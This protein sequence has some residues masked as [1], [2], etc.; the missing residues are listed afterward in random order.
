MQPE[1]WEKMT[2]YTPL[3]EMVNL[4]NIKNVEKIEENIWVIKN[5]VS[6][7]ILKEYNDY[8]QTVPEE[9]WWKRNKDWW[10]GKYLLVDND[11]P[12]C[13]VSRKLTEQI[14]LLFNDDIYL[15]AFGSIHRLT[16]G[17]GMFI[18]TDNPTEKRMLHDENGNEVGNTGGHNNYCILAMVAYLNDFQLNPMVRHSSTLVY[19]SS[20]CYLDYNT[21]P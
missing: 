4:E 11:S 17:Q 16:P 19:I 18:H 14:R 3:T 12:V 8:I 20:L 10:V 7:E 21:T 2:Q 6:K 15:G 1:L 13:E 5:F 9:E